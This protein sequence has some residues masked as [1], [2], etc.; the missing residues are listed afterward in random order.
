MRSPGAP[1]Y[2]MSS[3]LFTTNPHSLPCVDTSSFALHSSLVTKGI[4]TD[5]RDFKELRSICDQKQ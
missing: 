5:R 4:D 2:L 3:V 1:F